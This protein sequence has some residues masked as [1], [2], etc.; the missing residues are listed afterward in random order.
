MKESDLPPTELPNPK[1]HD[2]DRLPPERAAE[3]LLVEEAASVGRLPSVKGKIA[4]TALMA[5]R[6]IRAGGRLVYVGAGTSGRLGVLDAV[7]CVPTFRC[8]PGLVVGVIAGGDRALKEAV[9]GAEDDTEAGKRSLVDLR[10]DEKDTVVG[11]AA[12]GRTPF[13]L[14]ALREARRRG[15]G[16]AFISTELPPD[17]PEVDVFIPLPVGPEVLAG[18]TRLKA[19]TATKIVL[20]A[21]STTAMIRLGK[22]YRNLMVDLQPTN[23]KLRRRAVRLVC[24][25]ADAKPETAEKI[26]RETDWEV[27]TAVLVLKASVP[28]ARARELLKQSG[29][30]L[31][32]A[33]CACGIKP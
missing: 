10:V 15:A 24:E 32:E 7:E 25:L 9:E 12:C 30:R 17:A 31:G 28:P 33:L 23:E 21:I 8:P 14:A 1:S 4:K 5:E 27:K 2:L 6:S 13:V 3:L 19:G 22:V 20:N 11:I 29:G 16:T 18:S 26:L